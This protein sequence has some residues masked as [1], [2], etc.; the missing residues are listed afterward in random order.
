MA[1]SIGLELCAVCAIMGGLLAQ[2]VLKAIS[3]RDEPLDNVG[4]FNAAD[5]A[6]VYKHVVPN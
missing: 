5:G 3:H 1:L 2:E 4:V 6:A